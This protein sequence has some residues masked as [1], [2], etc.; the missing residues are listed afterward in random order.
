[1]CSSDLTDYLYAIKKRIRS[2]ICETL[3]KN[4]YTK[5]SKMIEILGCD[6]ETFANHI[7][8]QFVDGMNWNNRNEWHIDHIIPLASAK[9]E[10]E[11]LKLNHYT[12][13]QPLWAMD[14]IIKSDKF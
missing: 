4:G 11:I 6:Y 2:R 14:N 8:S 12:N 13:L 9:T 10:S 7:E 1:V 5:K 3:R